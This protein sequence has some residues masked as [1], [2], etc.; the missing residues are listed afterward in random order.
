[1]SDGHRK[2]QVLLIESDLIQ[3]LNDPAEGDF[4]WIAPGKSAWDRWWSNSYASE[5]DFEVGINTASMK[6]FV[7]LAAEMNWQYQLVD[8]YWY[9]SPFVEGSWTPHPTAD[10]TTADPNLDILE[11]IRYA[12]EKGVKIILWLH[13]DHA[14]KQMDEAFPLYEQ[15]RALARF[16][17]THGDPG[18]L[19]GQVGLPIQLHRELG[20]ARLGQPIDL[21]LAD[22][23]GIGAVLS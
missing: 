10:I 17:A 18:D 6:Y 13:W 1:M 12:R 11:V 4:S 23:P 8:F 22:G 20:V 5:V 15:R 9:G 14:D 3:N 19:A 21:G 2:L 7:D 16:A